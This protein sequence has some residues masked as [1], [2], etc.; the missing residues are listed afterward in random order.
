MAA[1]R[2][3]GD[4]IDVTFHGLEYKFLRR[5]DGFTYYKK[6]GKVAVVY[7]S[8]SC[9]YKA[10]IMIKQLMC[11]SRISTYSMHKIRNQNMFF[12]HNNRLWNRLC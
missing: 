2:V 11:T 9:K 1:Q 6:F 7:N 3:A 5:E 8:T 10:K 12:R 4:G